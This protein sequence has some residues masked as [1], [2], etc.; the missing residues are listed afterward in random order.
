MS[1][2]TIRLDAKLQRE[3]D[4]LCR[5]FGRTHVVLVVAVLALTLATATVQAQVDQRALAQRIVGTN[6][7]DQDNA[8]AQVLALGP[9]N[10]GPE[11]RAAL[12]TLL[13]RNNRLVIQ[14]VKRDEAV[15]TLVNPEFVAHVAHVVSQLEDPNAIPALAGALGTGSTLVRDAL[16]DFGERAAADVLRVVTALARSDD[17][18]ND[19][20]TTLRFMVEGARTRPLSAGTLDAIRRAAKQR[21]TGKQYFTTVWQ[22]IDLAVTLQ[23]AELRRTVQSLATDR[24]EVVARG[25]EEPDLIELTQKRA[26]GRLAGGPPL[27]RHR[28]SAERSRLLDPGRPR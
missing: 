1:A 27:P 4:R 22:A 13:D 23:D 18:V 6:P 9:Q 26:A 14:A 15:E 5:R 24:N 10:A 25:I 21:L 19:G 3:L 7:T 2:G 20:L 28:S 11:L 12:I 8:V 16:A 17:A